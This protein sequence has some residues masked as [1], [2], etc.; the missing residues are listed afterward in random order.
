MGYVKEAMM[1]V[2]EAGCLWIEEEVIARLREAGHSP[3]TRLV[4]VEG[5][6]GP[7]ELDALPATEGLRLLPLVDGDDYEVIADALSNFL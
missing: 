4:V 2:E 3:K 5:Y 7:V 6:D 1:A